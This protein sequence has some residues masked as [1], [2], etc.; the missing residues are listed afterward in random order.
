MAIAFDNRAS[1][2]G[3]GPSVTGISVPSGE[4]ASWALIGRE[5]TAAGTGGTSVVT[6]FWGIVTTQE[7]VST[8]TPTVTL[9][10]AIGAHTAAIEE[11]SGLTLTNRGLASI[12]HSTAGAPSATVTGPLA[13]DLVVGVSGWETA[14]AITGDSDTTNG[15]WSA[16]NSIA[17]SGGGDAA[18]ILAA[19][20]WKIV[21]ADGAQ[22]YNPTGPL[23][24]AGVVLAALQPSG[25]TPPP[26]TS[27]IKAEAVGGSQ[28]AVSSSSVTIG[29]VKHDISSAT[30]A[31]GGV[32]KVIP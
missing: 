29:G 16:V 12:N 3:G 26:V 22:T 10:V 6:E 19:L 24:D 27:A 5:E 11:F 28:K 18:N 7:W 30:V 9:S 25:G 15:S 2:L 4:S 23:T 31:V 32:K 13:G 14:L 1:S 8:F 17:T 20:Q 21:S